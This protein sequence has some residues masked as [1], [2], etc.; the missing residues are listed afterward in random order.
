[1]GGKPKPAAVTEDELVTLI[2]TV[3][4]EGVIDEERSDLLQSA[5]EFSEIEAQEITTHRVD[6]LAIDIEEPLDEVERI[7]NHSPFSRIPVYEGSIDNII[8]VLQLNHFYKKMLD[9]RDFELRDILTP[10]CFV[11]QTLHL[12]FVLAEMKRRKLHLAVVVDEYAARWASSRWKTCSSSWWATSG[13][14][15]TRL[16]TSVIKLTRR[17]TRCAAP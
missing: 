13:T 1:M 15:P 7:V 17:T 4:D 14:R 16:S 12:P 8:G 5:I 3:E 11:P 9:G 6:M 10:A 2:E